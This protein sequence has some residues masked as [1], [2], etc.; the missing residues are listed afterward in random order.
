[1][2]ASISRRAPHRVAHLE[3]WYNTMYNVR[4]GSRVTTSLQHRSPDLLLD[5]ASTS[6]RPYPPSLLVSLLLIE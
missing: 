5:A 3:W 6:G 4:S 1:M 2:I